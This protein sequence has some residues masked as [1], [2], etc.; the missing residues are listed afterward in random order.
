MKS[1]LKSCLQKSLAFLQVTHG[2]KSYLVLQ[3]LVSQREIL[4]AEGRDLSLGNISYYVFTRLNVSKF[5]ETSIDG[6]SSPGRWK[7]QAANGQAPATGHRPPF[8]SAY[9][10]ARYLSAFDQHS[11]R[12]VYARAAARYAIRISRA[13]S[14]VNRKPA[15]TQSA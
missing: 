11:R 15:F 2:I 4:H 3:T 10:V 12:C 8:V 14:V 9:T 13:L 7:F 5:D 1:D 6:D